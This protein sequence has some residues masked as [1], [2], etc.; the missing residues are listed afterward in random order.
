MKKLLNVD[1]IGISF[2]GLKAVDG[3]TFEV[4]EGEI[5]GV[6]GPNGAGKTTLV[7][8]ISGVIKPSRGTVVFRD[9]TVTGMA[10]SRLTE[11]GLVRTFQSTAVYAQRSVREN[12][13]RGSYL[14]RYPGALATLFDTPRARRKRAESDGQVEELLHRMGLAAVADDAAGSLPYGMQKILG[15][16]IALAARPTLL[17]LD[18]PVAGLSAEETDQVRDAILRVRESGVTVMVIDHNMRFI[19]GLCDR[20]LVVASGQELTRGKPDEVLRDRRVVEA[21]LGTRNVTAGIA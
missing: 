1:G 3:V 7:N 5:L 14:T 19:A 20:L 6:I 16:A 17:M 12:I 4:Y 9:E 21:Y 11:R 15:I 13:V 18:E 10:P 8:L 2:G